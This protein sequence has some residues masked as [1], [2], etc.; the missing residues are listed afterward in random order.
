M[1]YRETK[2]IIGFDFALT[3]S[4]PAPSCVLFDIAS[5]LLMELKWLMLNKHKRWFLSS[6]VKFPLVSMSASW[7][8]GVNEFDLDLV[9][10]NWFYPTTNQEQLC[11]FWK[12]V[13][14]S[15]FFP[16]WSSWSLLRCLQS[17]TTKLLM[18]RIHIWGNKINI[19]QIIYHSLR[20]LAFLDCVRWWT[21]F[22]FVLWQVALFCTVLIRVSKNCEIRSHKSSAGTIQPQS[23]RNDFLI[24]FNCVKLK[25]V[26]CT[27]N[28]LEQMYDFQKR[29][30]FLEKWILSPQDSCKVGILK[31]SQSALFGSATHITILFVFTYV[32]NV[33]YQTK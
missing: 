5:R 31:Q 21:N 18:R 10:P 19:T 3:L 4:S 6:R 28:L 29:T 2:F 8:F 32:M 14:L 7:F 22:T 9:C 23:Q 11:G 33:R 17:C 13:S 27:S 20:L 15:G 30:M 25:F 26:S 12:H 24:L 1:L 16:L